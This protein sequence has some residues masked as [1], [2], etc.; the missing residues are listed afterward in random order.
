ML[1]AGDEF[2]RTQRGNNNAFCQDNE[3]G[4]V[5]WRLLTID[6]G[7]SLHAFVGRLVQLRAT[8]PV[9]RE[10]WI[11]AAERTS[12]TSGSAVTW[13]DPAGRTLSIAAL[14]T[15]A[16]NCLGWSLG[17]P[18]SRVGPDGGADGRGADLSSDRLLTI[19]NRGTQE[20][21]FTLPTLVLPLRWVLLMD[22]S[23]ADAFPQQAM[24]SGTTYRAPPHSVV[25]LAAAT[26][27]HA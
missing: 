13:R 9:L 18:A 24:V 1:L 6:P 19:L 3:I 26:A 22:T 15:T 27:A 11:R 16:P 10:M 4:W 25:L 8:C 5:D 21:P 12:A 2:G 7:A 17:R 20:V 23:L 14:D